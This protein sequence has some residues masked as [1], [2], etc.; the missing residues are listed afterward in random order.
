[1]NSTSTSLFINNSN[2]PSSLGESQFL[3]DINSLEDEQQWDDENDRLDE[4]E[5]QTRRTVKLVFCIGYAILFLL[6][7]LGNGY[8]QKNKLETL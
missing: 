7:T 8:Y 6:G 4:S 2:L 5:M 1:M 3:A